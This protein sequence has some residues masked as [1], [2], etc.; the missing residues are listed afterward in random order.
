MELAKGLTIPGVSSKLEDHRPD[1]LPMASGVWGSQ[2]RS[3]QAAQ[4]S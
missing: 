4:G 3:G 1:L 2:G